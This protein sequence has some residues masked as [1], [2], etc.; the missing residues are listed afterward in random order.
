MSETIR[1]R[2]LYQT[3]A[4]W[5][6]VTATLLQRKLLRAARIESGGTEGGDDI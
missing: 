5:K 2:S 4:T 6:P 3:C 1:L